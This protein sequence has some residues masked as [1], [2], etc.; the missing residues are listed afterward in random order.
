MP[1]ADDLVA[2][3]SLAGNTVVA[4][5]AT[6]AWETVRKGIVQLFGRGG[7]RR[8][9]MAGSWLDTAQAQLAALSEAELER[10]RVALAQRWADRLADLIEEDPAAADGLKLLV[11]KV[12]AQLPTVVLSAVNY[13]AVAGRD[14][15]IA[16]DSGVAAGLM[17]DS[18]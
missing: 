13:S 1:L 10:A 8:A 5:A 9:Q 11:G 12:Q 15:N 18:V 17:Q 14:Q 2:L 3:A 16:A 7:K 4:A 6:D